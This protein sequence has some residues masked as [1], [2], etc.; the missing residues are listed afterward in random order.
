MELE[1]V[2]IFDVLKSSLSGELGVVLS[3]S[4]NMLDLRGK[5]GVVVRYKFGKH[6]FRVPQDEAVE[7]RKLAR[8]ACKKQEAAT[9]RKKR[10][11]TATAFLNKLARRR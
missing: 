7:F 6:F 5:T 1:E 4:G 3:I 8:E 9:G 11:R 2:R 10:K